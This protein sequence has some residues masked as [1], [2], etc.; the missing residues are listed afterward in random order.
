VA[1]IYPKR[2]RLFL[3][4]G[5]IIASVVFLALTG[6]HIRG[7]FKPFDMID[8]LEKSDPI[9]VAYESHEKKYY[10]RS[11]IYI[12]IE[13][14]EKQADERSLLAVTSFLH[15][16]LG[17]IPNFEDLDSVINSEQIVVE[18]GQTVLRK[19]VHDGHLTDLAK[20]RFRNELAY[21][22]TYLNPTLDA[23]L[24]N[25]KA[26]SPLTDKEKATL[27]ATVLSLVQKFNSTHGDFRAHAIGEVIVQDYF[28]TEIINNQKIVFPIIL[29]ISIGVMF[30]FFRSIPQSLT[31]L[32]IILLSYLLVLNLVVFLESEVNPFSSFALMLTIVVAT[33]NC[34]HYL[35][36]F[37]ERGREFTLK[38]MYLT[39]KDVFTPCVLATMTTVVACAGLIISDIKPVKYFG[40]YTCIGVAS[41]FLF[42]VYL[43]PLVIYLFPSNRQTKSYFT[44]I[45]S[46]AIFNFSLRNRYKIIGFYFLMTGFFLVFAFRMKF[47]DNLYK[48]FVDDHPLSLAIESFRKNFM[49]TG[50]IEV[51]LNADHEYFRTAESEKLQDSLHAEILNLPNVGHMKSLF[52]YQKLLRNATGNFTGDFVTDLDLRHKFNVLEEAETLE[53]YLP[54]GDSETRLEV[55]VKSLDTKDMMATV[56]GITKILEKSKYS[57]YTFHIGGFSKVRM[58]IFKNILT[59][60]SESAVYDILF[61]FLV[62]LI[63]YRSVPWAIAAMI[64]SLLPVVTVCGIVGMLGMDAECNI[65]LMIS[66]VIGIAVDDTAY[67]FHVFR[68]SLLKKDS[69]YK[70][71]KFTLD[72]CLN[73]MIATTII[74]IL[75]T[76]GLFFTQIKLYIQFAGVLMISLLIGMLADIFVST[77]M[78]LTVGGC[79]FAGTRIPRYSRETEAEDFLGHGQRL[80]AEGA[81]HE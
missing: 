74:F 55:F 63:A 33:S 38:E 64:P 41:S 78:F 27:S 58:Q 71:I 35:S 37:N 21:R 53:T 43:M 4:S 16:Q 10:D 40:I 77:A 7:A 80:V 32:Y 8:M 61:V 68:E 57:P 42:S 75:S 51:L 13:T 67:Y 50:S 47:D 48:K 9:R 54:F 24:I 3:K 81:M 49:F 5:F 65:V 44:G 12:E 46:R 36:T 60:F 19:F 66:L 39:R 56:D 72:H 73:A 23:S 20:M 6:L 28:L 79:R 1:V 11:K 17:K 29:I 34:I 69:V 15:Q 59:S 14:V 25:L 45:D 22:Y 18:N 2:F 26:R 76:A 62:F 52:Y 30:F 31:G 70:S